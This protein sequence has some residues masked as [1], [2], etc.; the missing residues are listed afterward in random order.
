LH[1]HFVPAACRLAFGYN[2]PN[3]FGRPDLLSLPSQQVETHCAQYPTISFSHLVSA[4]V[5]ALD[6]AKNAVQ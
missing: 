2:Y 4:N 5:C 3:P 1:I 6:V